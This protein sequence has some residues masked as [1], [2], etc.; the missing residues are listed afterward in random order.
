MCMLVKKVAC[1]LSFYPDMKEIPGSGTYMRQVR[2]MLAFGAVVLFL[3]V[4]KAASEVTLPIALALFIFAFANPLMERLARLKVPNIISV[5]LVL[6]LVVVLFFGFIYV[7][8]LMVNML[9]DRVDY[10]AERIRSLDALLSGYLM[11][12]FPEADEDFSILS[13]VNVDWYGLAVSWLTS[14]SSK[15]ISILSD[16]MMIFVT[17]LFLLLER[18]TFLPKIAFAFPRDKSQKFSSMLGR[19]NRQMS[20]YLLL[21][22]IISLMT[23]LL[24]YLTAIV[25]GLDFAL[26][27]GVLAVLLNFI[28]TIGSIIV[29]ALT[30]L[31]SIIQFAPDAWINIVYVVILTISIEMVLGNIIDPRLQ[32]VQLN[33][34]PLMILISLSLWGFI[35]GLPG[36]FL[37]V[38]IMSI[39]QIVCAIVPS[40]KPVAVLLSSGKTYVREY[41]SQEKSRRLRR[42]GADGESDKPSGGDIILPEGG[43]R[44]E[45][46]EGD[47]QA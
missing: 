43:N 45:D 38:P 30:I 19:I 39:I 20:K 13:Y 10:Y 44:K 9:L 31:M 41:R 6:A 15:I 4:L 17:L 25:T 1:A 26:V 24:F 11:D 22:A 34:S 42:R 21:K 36:M 18:T 7:L 23:G 35:W 47:G 29:T 32:G 14:F 33:M 3:F 12:Y 8:I 40:L 5:V 16:S 27:W 37:A 46:G 28:P 2:N